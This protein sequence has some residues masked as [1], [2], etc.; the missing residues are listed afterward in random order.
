MISTCTANLNSSLSTLGH[1]DVECCLIDLDFDDGDD[2]NLNTLANCIVLQRKGNIL[3]VYLLG[4][5]YSI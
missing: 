1:T 5:N 2:V 3:M 4:T